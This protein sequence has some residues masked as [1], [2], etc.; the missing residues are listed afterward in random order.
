M[1]IEGSKKESKQILCNLGK[2]YGRF[3]FVYD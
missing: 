1:G 2:M 3:S